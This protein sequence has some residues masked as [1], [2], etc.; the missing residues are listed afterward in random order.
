MTSDE[1][2]QFINLLGKNDHKVVI[3]GKSFI[4]NPP[5]T[6]QIATYKFGNWILI[7]GDPLFH[8][9][10]GMNQDEFTSLLKKESISRTLFH[11]CVEETSGSLGFDFI[12]N[13]AVL[14]SWWRLEGKVVT[15]IGDPIKAETPAMFGPASDLNVSGDVWDVVKLAESFGF[16]YDD[17]EVIKGTVYQ[18]V[19]KEEPIKKSKW[20]FWQ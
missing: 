13:G 1:A 10:Y 6:G 14:R 4:D 16:K 7:Y 18:P 8:R 2:I 17:L 11:W 3:D 12:E 5:E 15:C 9:D 20:K 19:K